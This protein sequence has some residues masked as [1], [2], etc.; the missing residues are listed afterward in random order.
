MC[1]QWIAWPGDKNNKQLAQPN[2][3]KQSTGK[4]ECM[5]EAPVFWRQ[6]LSN[7]GRSVLR[8]DWVWRLI[9]TGER[10]DF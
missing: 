4:I 3:M 8:T 1:L 7:T 9:L 5:K 2:L 10:A 6:R